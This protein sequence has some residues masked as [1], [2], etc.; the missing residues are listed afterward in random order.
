MTNGLLRVR[1][2]KKTFPGVVALNGVQLE[3]G[4]GEV[5]A[6]LGENGA[7]KSTMLKIL[8]GAQPPDSQGRSVL[9]TIAEISLISMF[10]GRAIG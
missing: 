5:H 10:Y 2:I 4:T 1:D 6:L 7:G 9:I 8:S 3:V